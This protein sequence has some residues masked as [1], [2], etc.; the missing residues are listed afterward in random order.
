M[1]KIM[2]IVNGLPGKMADII[3]KGIIKQEENEGYLFKHAPF[4]MTGP[5]IEFQ[6]WNDNVGLVQPETF[7]EMI[8]TAKANKQRLIAIDFTTPFDAE[9]RSNAEWNT[10]LYC[11]LD[12]PFV[13]GTTGGNHEIIQSMV[14]SSQNLALVAPNFDRSIVA[15]CDAI[16]QMAQDHPGIYEGYTPTFWESHQADKDD[17]SGTAKKLIADISTLLGREFELDEIDKIREPRIQ[18]IS[19]GVPSEHLDWHAYH[20][21]KVTNPDGS[22]E[23]VL[24]NTRRHGG[25]CYRQ[26]VEPSYRFIA[27]K[28]LKGEKGYF[29]ASDLP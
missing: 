22:I 1:S 6:Y 18:L 5:E 4:S 27:E 23:D 21:A 24:L 8:V 11:E 28:I 15:Q 14:E 17:T 12:L 26:G 13:M 3:A 19:L 20:L 7:R 2:L 10:R 9:G 25:E 16:H 29:N